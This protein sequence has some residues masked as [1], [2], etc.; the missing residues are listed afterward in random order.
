[1]E[2]SRVQVR[3]HKEGAES[4]LIRTRNEVAVAVLDREWEDR[5]AGYM[6]R[7]RDGRLVEPSVSQVYYLFVRDPFASGTGCDSTGNERLHGK[8]NRYYHFL[9]DGD[10]R[11]GLCRTG[12]P[13]DILNYRKYVTERN[14]YLQR[15]NVLTGQQ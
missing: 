8:H 15:R 5:R 11:C 12:L 6:I 1:M 14:I 2:E 4:E 3:A 10:I 7:T 9:V 13:E